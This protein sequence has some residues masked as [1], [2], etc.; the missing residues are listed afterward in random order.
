MREALGL[1]DVAI[2]TGEVDGVGTE[3]LQVVVV[4]GGHRE[5][6]GECAGR[7]H[8][9]AKGASESVNCRAPLSWRIS[10]AATN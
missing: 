2:G 1:T 6:E 4:I 9:Q 7:F 8:V 5:V 3:E 10:G